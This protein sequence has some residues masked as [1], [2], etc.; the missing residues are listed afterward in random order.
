VSRF[1]WFRRINTTDLKD[2]LARGLSDFE[3]YRS[4]VVFLCLIYPLIG[5]A[6]M[7]T[8][9]CEM[10]RWCSRLRSGSRSSVRSRLFAL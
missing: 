5:R 10:L 6:G 9:G 8:F 1:P 2:V 7:L 4:G 3:V